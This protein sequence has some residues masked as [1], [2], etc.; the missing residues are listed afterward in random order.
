MGQA[1]Y[2]LLDCALDACEKRK[3]KLFMAMAYVFQSAH[4][5]EPKVNLTSRP[6]GLRER[7]KKRE[8]AF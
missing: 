2:G 7:R 4:S 3:D 5:S 1:G 8:A 6:L